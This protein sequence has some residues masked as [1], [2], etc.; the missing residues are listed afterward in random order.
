[1]E[2]IIINEEYNHLEERESFM[3]G[4]YGKYGGKPLTYIALCAISDSH[5]LHII[6][7]IKD[8]AHVIKRPNVL[9]LMEEEA[10][11]RT[12]NFIF[13]PEYE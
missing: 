13:I 9:K 6:E 8:T 3:W 11:Y 5:L 2:K 7:H 12:K 4:S 1:M 10:N